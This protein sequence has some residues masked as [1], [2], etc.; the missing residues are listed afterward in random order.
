MEQPNMENQVLLVLME[1]PDPGDSSWA[2]RVN[3]GVP[4]MPIAA[5]AST[6]RYGVRMA[7]KSPPASR[8]G[9]QPE[10]CRATPRN[11]RVC[12]T[13][14]PPPGSPKWNSIPVKS[15]DRRHR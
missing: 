9:A 2:T 10:I 15:A 3:P 8:F 11:T 1:K 13:G 7:D 12:A 6:G 5:T 4:K 14:S